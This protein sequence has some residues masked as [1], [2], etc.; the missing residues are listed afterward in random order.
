M[1][2]VVDS[3][4]KCGL[5]DS[6]K[7]VLTRKLIVIVLNAPTNKCLMVK[8]LLSKGTTIVVGWGL[9]DFAELVDC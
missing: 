8:F 1:L 2:K 4:R 5:G 6:I 9:S 3:E 7:T